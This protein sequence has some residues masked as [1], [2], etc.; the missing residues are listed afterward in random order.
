MGMEEQAAAALA[1]A[2][3]PAAQLSL[4]RLRPGRAAAF[5]AG[6]AFVK[7]YLGPDAAARAGAAHSGQARAAALSGPGGPLAPIPGPL[8]GAAFANEWLEAERFG[9][10]MRARFRP[11]R[12]AALMEAAGAALARLHRGAPAAPLAFGGWPADALLKA[13]ARA[14][15]APWPGFAALVGRACA[16]LHE[17]RAE[18][19]PA[20]PSHG[21]LHAENLLVVSGGALRMVDFAGDEARPALADVAQ[22]L[23]TAAARSPRFP[24]RGRGRFGLA[25]ADEAA[26]FAGYGALPAPPP[27][28]ALHILRVALAQAL[29]AADPEREGAGSRGRRRR[30][31]R[32]RALAE[33]AA[34]RAG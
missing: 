23:V 4:L 22:L 7:V 12:R 26:F 5:R 10:L 32:L 1:A 3:F 14:G 6:G 27:L 25:A 15:R 28:V 17:A 20:G 29:L 19:L 30:L 33:A 21:D 9:D 16:K 13:L 18:P 31:A 34:A 8:A 11:S 24:P 2:G